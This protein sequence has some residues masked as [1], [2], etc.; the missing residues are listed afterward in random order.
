MPVIAMTQEMGSL[1]KDVALQL[2]GRELELLDPAVLEQR[3][4]LERFGGRAE[5]RA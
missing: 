5:A 4:A 2:L 1:A 3:N